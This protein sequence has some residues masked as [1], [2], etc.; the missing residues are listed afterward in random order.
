M[1]HAITI[2]MLQMMILVIDFSICKSFKMCKIEIEEK[3]KEVHFYQVYEEYFLNMDNYSFFCGRSE[4]EALTY[5]CVNRCV[6]TKMRARENGLEPVRSLLAIDL[7][8][9]PLFG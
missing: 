4:E 9:H 3:R 7:K 6:W 5:R 2:K 8:I 1:Y